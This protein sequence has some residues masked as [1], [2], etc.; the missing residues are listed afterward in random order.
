VINNIFN[1]QPIGN[2]NTG[3]S[4]TTVNS[5]VR[6]LDAIPFRKSLRLDME[7]WQHFGGKVDYPAACFWYGKE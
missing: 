7:S 5:R 4:G 3:A 2:A 1:G 6:S